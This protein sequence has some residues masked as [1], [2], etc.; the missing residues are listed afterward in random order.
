MS[1]ESIYIVVSG[2]L[3]R[4][5]PYALRKSYYAE[6]PLVELNQENITGLKLILTW[7]EAALGDF[8]KKKREQ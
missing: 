4:D 1:L 8:F 3:N 5:K 7:D 6:P 2:A